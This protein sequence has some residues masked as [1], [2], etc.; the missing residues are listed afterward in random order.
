MK[1]DFT[2]NV[3]L[4]ASPQEIYEA[5][6]SSDGHSAMTGSPAKVQAERGGDFTA[7]DGY[8]F[9]KSLELEPYRRFVQSWRTTE[10]PE[11]APDSRIEITLE[12]VK[13]GTK[14]TLVHSGLPEGSVDSYHTGWE[15]YYFK[16]M[17]EYFS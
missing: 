10:F 17:K 2:M 6:L 16:P 5:W 8:I 7:W 1:Q 12:A 9:G 3:T 13:N 14:L 11:D 15:D 4:D